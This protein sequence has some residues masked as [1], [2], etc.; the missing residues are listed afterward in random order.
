MVSDLSIV[1]M[2]DV[3]APAGLVACWPLPSRKQEGSDRR[4]VGTHVSDDTPLVQGFFQGFWIFMLFRRA[5][6]AVTSFPEKHGFLGKFYKLIQV[7][8]DQADNPLQGCPQGAAD[9]I[10][11]PPVQISPIDRLR[12]GQNL[13]FIGPGHSK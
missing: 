9:L 12:E 1:Q 5:A 7:V 3:P 11:H 6:D 13:S 10:P 4:P 2:M 8:E